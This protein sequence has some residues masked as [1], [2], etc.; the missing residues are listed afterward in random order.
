MRYNDI[1]RAARAVSVGSV[2]IGG[3]APIAIQSMTNTDTLDREATL[4]QVQALEKA[5]CDIVRLTVPSAEAAK[6]ISYIKEK[7]V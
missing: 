5:G 2:V 7:G 1:R 6:T 4:S 3:S